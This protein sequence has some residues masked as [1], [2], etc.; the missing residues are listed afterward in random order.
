MGPAS[1]FAQEAPEMRGKRDSTPV[2]LQ[3]VGCVL[4]VCP[5]PSLV[6]DVGGGAF[7]NLVLQDFAPLLWLH[8]VHAQFGREPAICQFSSLLSGICPTFSGFQRPPGSNGPQICIL[9]EF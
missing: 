8:P 7:H 9:S 6:R 4:C 2:Q 5:C 3:S 1:D